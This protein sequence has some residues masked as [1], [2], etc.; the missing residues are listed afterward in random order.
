MA[1]FTDMKGAPD[2]DSLKKSA[3]WLNLLMEAVCTALWII[4]ASRVGG[5]W[6]WGLGYVVIKTVWSGYTF[7][8][9]LDFAGLLNG[10][11]DWLTFL[12]RFF[13]HCFGAICAA[14][15]AGPLGLAAD[16]AKPGLSFF[17]KYTPWDCTKVEGWK[18]GDSYEGCTG[19]TQTHDGAFEVSFWEFFFC[20]EMIAIFLFT[21]FVARSRDNSVPKAIWDILMI[22]VAFWLGGAGSAH[23][24][25]FFF[26]PARAFNSWAAFCSGPAWAT[27]ICQMWAVLL[28]H[29]FLAYVW[30]SE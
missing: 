10:S 16:G 5:V 22:T 20:K 14:A 18:D 13:A 24:S 15:L 12:L 25:S 30:K 1:L 19:H 26:I 7:N 4:V 23:G 9:L 6:G 3:T 27:L 11:M 28:A 29:V 2:V 21:C 17:N 8:S